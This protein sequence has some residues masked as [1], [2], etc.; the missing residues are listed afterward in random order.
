MRPS[1]RR[2]LRKSRLHPLALTTF[3]G[4]TALMPILAACSSG[5]TSTVKTY[6]IKTP[7]K[8]VIVIMQENRSF[9]SYFGTFPG[10]DGLPRNAAG[11]FTTCSPD[12]NTF[13]CVYP[14]H[15]PG[16]KN[17]GGPHGAPNAVAD[18]AGGKMNGFQASAEK[19]QRGCGNLNDPAC[20]NATVPDV[21][22]YHDAREIPNYW[23]VR[24]GLRPAGS[25]V[26]AE[27]LLEPARRTSS[28]SP[29][30]PPSAASRATRK[31]ASTRSRAPTRPEPRRRVAS[32]TPTTPGPTS[33]TCSTNTM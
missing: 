8:H 33:P 16:D 24:P 30:G 20:T 29:S 32:P 5:T 14:Y 25:H 7:I 19:G 9:D 6:P 28:W 26:R 15:D 3:V 21:M 27:R 23:H 31:A 4:L 10:A 1:P 18:I 17:G 22:G 2:L 12:P 11:Q 13:T